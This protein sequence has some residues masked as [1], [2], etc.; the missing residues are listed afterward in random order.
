MV[1]IPLVAALAVLLT[2]APPVLAQAQMIDTQHPLDHLTP[3][4]HWAVYHILRASGR[5]DST[6]VIAYVALHEPPK[7]EVLAWRAGQDFRREAFVRLI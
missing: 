5:T 6:M 4:E 7:A 3:D 1:R 2:A